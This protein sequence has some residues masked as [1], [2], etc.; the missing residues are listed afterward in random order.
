MWR[1]VIHLCA[2]FNKDLEECLDLQKASIQSETRTR[3]CDQLLTAD[4]EWCKEC[5]RHG[6]NGAGFHYVSIFSRL[7]SSLVWCVKGNAMPRVLSK[8][9]SRRE[10]SHASARGL[11]WR[12]LGSSTGLSVVFKWP[13]WVETLSQNHV[14][15]HWNISF[16]SK[17]RTID[18]TYD[19]LKLGVCNQ[20][21]WL[22]QAGMEC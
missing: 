20:I 17:A 3:V 8:E 7:M 6:R 13:F 5:M 2:K 11:D 16:A 15:C 12:I 18:G 1:V 22:S 14:T 4:G 19:G 9:S 21:Q 10:V